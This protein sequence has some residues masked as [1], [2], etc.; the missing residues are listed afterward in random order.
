MVNRNQ[1]S[2]TRILIDGLLQGVRPAGYAVQARNHNAV[3]AAI[4]QRRADWGVAI[5]SV[6]RA[7]GLGF[8]PLCE[9]QY[10]FVVHRS[11]RARPAVAAFCQLL[12]DPTVRAQL[13]ELGFRVP[14]APPD[15]AV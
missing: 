11:R 14:T 13:R 7:Q 12:E 9:E 15:H 4:A 3:A 6:A 5:Q 1:G 2:G 10:D 8:L